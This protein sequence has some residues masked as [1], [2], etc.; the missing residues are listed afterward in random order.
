MTFQFAIPVVDAIA[1]TIQLAE[2]AGSAWPTLPGPEGLIPVA[3]ALSAAAVARWFWF[4]QG[5]Q[6]ARFERI[7][8]RHQELQAVTT[9][10]HEA[11][12]LVRLF[13]GTSAQ[14]RTLNQH[15]ADA[16]EAAERLDSQVARARQELGT[17]RLHK[18]RRA[19]GLL[20]RNMR[21]LERDL[22][23]VQDNLKGL[24]DDNQECSRCLGSVRS[25]RLELV[26]ASAR[27]DVGWAKDV[28]DALDGLLAAIEQA[29]TL[30]ATGD[31]VLALQQCRDVG[32]A[33][34]GHRKTLESRAMTLRWLRAVPEQ[35]RRL[36]AERERLERAGFRAL[37]EVDQA[38][39][40][41]RSE[42]AVDLFF[43]GDLEGVSRSQQALRHDIEAFRRA[44]TGREELW[45]AND[46]EVK[47]LRTELQTMEAQLAA[48][49]PDGIVDRYS[50][51]L[52]R[53]AERQEAD[54]RSLLARLWEMLMAAEA[55]NALT[56]QRFDAA[57]DK[58]R[59]AAALRAIVREE[60]TRTAELWH[61]PEREE[62]RLRALLLSLMAEAGE[63][64]ANARLLGMVHDPMVEALIFAARGA[65][66]SRP[67]ALDEA[68]HT[69]ESA[70]TALE[71]YRDRHSEIQQRLEPTTRRPGPIVFLRQHL[72]VPEDT[73]TPRR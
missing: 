64:H 42:A 20:E 23:T 38:G 22:K 2:T 63:A 8:D 3:T 32:H 52:W 30:H 62:T 57:R 53:P 61:A 4:G 45:W 40:K 11:S 55:D 37:P 14:Y 33:L 26:K 54:V 15:F 16:M 24:T 9:K 49:R 13:S 58:L 1:G 50:P 73:E 28:R 43:A 59:Q 51:R 19:L 67:P 7:Q 29:E 39:F 27:P 66:D 21:D 10:L 41:Q 70:S 31:V 12:Q 60:L 56:T 72:E 46:R 35:A 25:R 5:D 17:W 47:A 65:L 34:Q 48:T 6:R 71:R 18:A 69:L 44:L 36:R 68:A